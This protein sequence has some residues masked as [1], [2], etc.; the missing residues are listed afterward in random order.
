MKLVY[1]KRTDNVVV[2]E[3][4]LYCHN[5]LGLPS[6]F[7]KRARPFFAAQYIHWHLLEMAWASSLLA[8]TPISEGLM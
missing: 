3:L 5:W 1:C 8:S 6:G 4:V 2:I 7:C